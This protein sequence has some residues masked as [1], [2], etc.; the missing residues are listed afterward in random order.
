MKRRKRVVMALLLA[1]LMLAGCGQRGLAF[2]LEVPA[3]RHQPLEKAAE[4]AAAETPVSAQLAEGV[5]TETEE[6]TEEEEPKVTICMVGDILLHTSLEE[7]AHQADGSYNYDALFANVKDDISAA[8]I[9]IV[10]QE[11]IIGGEQLGVT[12]YPSFNAPYPIG[13]A[14]VNAGFDV[15]CH[16]TNHALDRGKRGLLNCLNYWEENHPKIAVLGIN[17]SQEQ[18]DS[19]YVCEK[20][21]FKI[22]VLNYTYGTNGISMPSGMPYAVNLLDEAKVV[23]DLQKAEEMADF[24]VVCPHW[25]TEYNLGISE[26]QKKWTEIF[27]KNG[28]DLVLGTHPHVIE[29]IEMVTDEETGN[30]MLVYYSLGNFV[31]GTSDTGEGIANRSFGGLAQV[32]IARDKNGQ[33]V[34]RDYGVEALVC[35][36]EAGIN[37][38][39]V[40]RLADYTEEQAARCTTVSSDENF[41]MQYGVDLCN[42]VWG[43]LWK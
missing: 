10:N 3:T 43:S 39:T 23:S 8:D 1:L 42:E 13:D 36:L 40:Y 5:Q 37:A 35:H 30:R 21:G 11:V 18:Q 14:L 24:V 33:V 28:V 25:G 4:G 22:A 6:V 17:R 12:G 32:T 41:S 27:V 7:S 20:N 26:Q 15:V 2:Y 38:K 34:I 16:G 19:I 29:P 31:S 9:A